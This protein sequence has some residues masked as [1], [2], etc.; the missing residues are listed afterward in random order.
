MKSSAHL[1]RFEITGSRFEDGQLL[2]SGK[3]LAGE[4][5]KDQLF[6]QPHGAASRPPKGAIGVALVMP[7]RRTQALLMGIEHASKRP[8]LPEGAAALYDAEGGILKIFAG[9]AILD[10]GA[11]SVTFTAGGWTINGPVTING[12]LHV[13]GYITS[14]SPDGDPE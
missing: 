4:E 7:G 6:I 10:V 9:G 14:D 2:I 13:T 12:T 3:G 8:D 1:T 11:R 5:F